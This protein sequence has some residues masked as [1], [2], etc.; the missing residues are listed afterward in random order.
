MGDFTDAEANEPL[1]EGECPFT[2]G[3]HNARRETPIPGCPD[4]TLRT[5]ELTEAFI[6]CTLPK[7]EWTHHAHL[8]VGLWH[9]LRH[10]AE[11][12]LWLLRD[13]IQRYNVST[14]V[15]NTDQAG[16]HETITRFYVWVINR[17]L[18]C[19]DRS[20]EI[21][22]LA[23]ELIR[24]CGGKDLPLRYYS[25]ERLFSVPARRGWVEPDLAPME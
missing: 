5:E 16:Y 13:R 14:G 7:K 10:P 22:Q 17:F 9:L 23:E 15:M 21:D 2:R 6:A 11:E 3:G 20:T 1:P 12:A 4:M 25:R 8:R 24:R 19:A 18:R